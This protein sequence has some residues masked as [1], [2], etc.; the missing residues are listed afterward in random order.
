MSMLVFFIYDYRIITLCCFLLTKSRKQ[1][2]D[3]ICACLSLYLFCLVQDLEHECC[4]CWWTFCAN[5]S[6]WVDERDK[7]S[8]WF[9]GRHEFTHPHIKSLFCPF[10]ISNENMSAVF[11][12]SQP[13]E[14]MEWAWASVS[15]CS[16]TYS[17][18]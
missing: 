1:H 13:K 17:M 7:G 4:G 3:L 15:V 12:T 9:W 6:L 2:I 16:Q 8:R 5:L 10:W 14:W 18:V 11:I